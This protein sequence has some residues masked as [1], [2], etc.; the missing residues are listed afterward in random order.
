MKKI[1]IFGIGKISDVLYYHLKKS[2]K[3]DI[4][5]FTV[6]SEYITV[7][8]KFSLPV[9]SF[10]N[11]VN[12]YPPSEFDMFISIGYQ[13][14]NKLR[15]NKYNKAKELGY[16]LVNYI[17][18]N[19]DNV[20]NIDIGENSVILGNC[21]LEPFSKVGNNTFIWSNSVIGHHSQIKDNC[22]ISASV[23]IG[24]SSIIEDNCFIG[25]N[26]TIGHEIKLDSQTFVG[27]ASVVLKNTESKSVFISP[28]TNKF[29]LDS[30]SFLKISKLK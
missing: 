22:F 24:G 23:N 6:D 19:A 5:A 11:I 25:L 21:S 18:P 15:E 29:R 12:L 17:S 30:E 7:E 3:F 28:D 16:N 27:A 20:S 2:N 4:V 1:V 14:M 13:N 10:E 8:N 9:V 26:S